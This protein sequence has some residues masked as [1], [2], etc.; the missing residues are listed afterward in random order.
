M[1]RLGKVFYG[2][3]QRDYVPSARIMEGNKSQPVIVFRN[4]SFISLALLLGKT[5]AL[6]PPTLLHV[7]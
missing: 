1:L 7:H 5:P 3:A 2:R 6:G 4:K